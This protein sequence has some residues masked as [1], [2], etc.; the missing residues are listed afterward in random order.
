MELV[1]ENVDDVESE[2][3]ETV[4]ITS[5]DKITITNDEIEYYTC[6][7]IKLIPYDSNFVVL[8]GL[9]LL[10]IYYK[11][12]YNIPHTNHRFKDIQVYLFGSKEQIQK[13]F[14][15][16]V[17]NI[18]SVYGPIKNKGENFV[19]Y[20][21][22]VS[23]YYN[24]Y[25]EYYFAN[26]KKTLQI[27]FVDC[28]SVTDLINIMESA[29]EMCYWTNNSGFKLSIYTHLACVNNQ[30][31]VNPQTNKIIYSET[32]YWLKT[33]GFNLDQYLKSHMFINDYPIAEYEARARRWPKLNGPNNTEIDFEYISRDLIDPFS[34]EKNFVS[35][36]NLNLH[37]K[38]FYDNE[39]F[40]CNNNN[41][42]Y[43]I[44]QGQIK[45]IKYSI[46]GNANNL[47]F[48]ISDNDVA[49]KFIEILN[50]CAKK[51]SNES[52]IKSYLVNTNFLKNNESKIYNQ[53]YIYPN[54][55][56][57]DN[58]LGIVCEFNNLECNNYLYY[59]GV[60]WCT[61]STG[62]SVS[63][64][65]LPLNQDVLAWIKI[66]IFDNSKII[67]FILDFIAL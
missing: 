55:Y 33:I 37:F 48:L 30:V 50:F 54:K 58:K 64:T 34:Y 17:K 45:E 24:Y 61:D 10:E 46:T 8:A 1:T 32:L 11:K 20:R 47:I 53:H 16:I 13:N 22:K 6:G 7:L 12:F 35:F 44:V 2:K 52:K 3:S 18:E 29:N 28:K 39:H 66:K 51:L 5:I 62:V 27:Y 56:F 57:D 21:V 40:I 49:N 15:Q 59:K 4:T 36:N 26:Y 19:E 38:K 42:R 43:I 9:F 65:S 23:D 31:M 60:V 67:M 63:E 14:N 25:K 41:Y